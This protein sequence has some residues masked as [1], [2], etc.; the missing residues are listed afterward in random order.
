LQVC[1]SL[2]P[3]GGATRQKAGFTDYDLRLFTVDG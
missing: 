2:I 3:P 1:C